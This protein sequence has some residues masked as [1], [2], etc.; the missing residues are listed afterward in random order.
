MLKLEAHTKKTQAAGGSVPSMAGKDVHLKLADDI[1]AQKDPI[2]LT[3]FMLKERNHFKQSNGSFNMLLQSIQLACKVIAN[4]NK[5]AG[6][7]NL[8]GI[9]G[10]SNSASSG[11]DNG[12]VWWVKKLDVLSDE[13]FKNCVSYSGQAYL[14]V[15]EEREEPIILKAN[16]G[17]YVIV[18]DPLD[19]SSN[20]D[21]NVSVGTI[22][23]IYKKDDVCSEPT[24]EK[25]CLRPGNELIASGYCLYGAACCLVLTTGLGVNG[26]T[27]DPTLGEFILTHPEIRI[28]VKGDIYSVN[29]GNFESWDDVTKAYV[30]QCRSKSNPMKGRYVGSMVADMHRTL[31]YGGV[32]MYPGTTSHPLGKLRLLYECNP[33][34]MIVE[35]A[36]GRATDG[37][38][39]ILDIEPTSIHQKSPIYLGSSQHVMEIEKLYRQ[40]PSL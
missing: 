24:S 32:F 16:K 37:K 8:T 20:I 7:A 23:G 3:R 31:L 18:F 12:K 10:S 29:E 35:Q 22:F 33:M 17:G 30:M 34:A 36:G 40:Q 39:R 1:E 21:A 14:A 4:A 11:E 28:P 26:F 2:T 25:H 38:R 19:G 6:I 15:S 5:R 13:V 9:V 27:L